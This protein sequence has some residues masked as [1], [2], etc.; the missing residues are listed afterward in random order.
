[1]KTIDLGP[2]MRGFT[3]TSLH[4]AEKIV[5]AEC[6]NVTATKQNKFYRKSYCGGTVFTLGIHICFIDDDGNE[7]AYYTPIMETL[8]ILDKP[9]VVGI[10]EDVIIK[11]LS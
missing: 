10:K 7:Y 6:P 4:S 9:R 3:C 5:K 1:M 11:P 2:G 8:A